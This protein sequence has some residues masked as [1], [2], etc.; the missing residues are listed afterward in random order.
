MGVLGVWKS[1][2]KIETKFVKILA[3]HP[4][5]IYKVASLPDFLDEFDIL[6]V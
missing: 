3:P 1:V 4:D 5:P 6:E 2:S